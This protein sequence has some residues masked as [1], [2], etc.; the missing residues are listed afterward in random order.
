M[1]D[2][3]AIGISY[4]QLFICYYMLLASLLF[5]VTIHKWDNG[6]SW[7]LQRRTQKATWD[8]PRGIVGE[9]PRPAIIAPIHGTIWLRPKGI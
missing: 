7:Q 1:R 6:I 4:L 5:F 9:G 2:K 8:D 3:L